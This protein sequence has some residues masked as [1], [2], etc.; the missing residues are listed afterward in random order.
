V[1]PF[2]VVGI[3]VY[4]ILGWLLSFV[5]DKYSWIDFF[6]VSA[7][8]LLG[9]LVF[10]FPDATQV[11]FL[12]NKPLILLTTMYFLWSSRLSI[13]LFRRIQGH[14]EDSRYQNMKNKLKSRMPAVML[15]LY[16]FEGG[17]VLILSLPFLVELE[18][19]ARNLG[20]WHMISGLLFVL[21][22]LG[23]VISDRQMNQFREINK[24]RKVVCDVGLWKYSRH[25]NYFFEIM[26][27]LSIAVF[28]IGESHFY[29]YC[30][31]FVIMTVFICKFTGIPPSEEQSLRTRGDLYREY[32]NK[33]SVLIPWFPKES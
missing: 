12:E 23:E 22:F 18:N 16:L 5:T 13:T 15:G 24:G 31:P 27:W 9:G 7:F 10:L 30:I 28:G 29:I 8:I 17:L 1:G 14:S 11:P 6:W 26:I 4:F 32:Q 33:T 21:A 25:P 3:L 19:P 20:N 2:N